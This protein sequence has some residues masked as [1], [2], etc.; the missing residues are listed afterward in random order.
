M[1]VWVC[2]RVC[3]EPVLLD[4]VT[5][6]PAGAPLQLLL[7]FCIV[8][9]Q[10]SCLCTLAAVAIQEK[11]TPRS[12]QSGMEVCGGGHAPL[13]HK[14]PQACNQGYGSVSVNVVSIKC[15]YQYVNRRPTLPT[16]PA[17]PYHPLIHSYLQARMR[18]SP[19]PAACEPQDVACTS[20]IMEASTAGNSV[21][22]PH[23][24]SLQARHTDLWV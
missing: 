14:V 5:S 15:I 23:M 24:I 11:G 19:S 20:L 6:Q 13:P 7:Y 4:D 10:G 12:M 18:A 2:M 8:S 16:S 22:L 3:T 17:S 21:G 9:W 1:H